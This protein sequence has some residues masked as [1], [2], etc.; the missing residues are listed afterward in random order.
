MTIKPKIQKEVLCILIW[1][2]F[3]KIFIKSFKLGLNEVY[4]GALHL[5]TVLKMLRK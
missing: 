3:L 5:Q 4:L 1:T 2:I